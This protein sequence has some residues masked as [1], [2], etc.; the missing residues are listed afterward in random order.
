MNS[1]SLSTT[2]R[3]KETALGSITEVVQTVKNPRSH[4]R[5]ASHDTSTPKYEGQSFNLDYMLPAPAE[6]Q[7]VGTPKEQTLRQDSRKSRKSS[8][9][10]LMGYIYSCFDFSSYSKF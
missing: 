7:S 5:S 6:T 4:I 8:R 9:I 1:F 3:Q 10:S 2:A